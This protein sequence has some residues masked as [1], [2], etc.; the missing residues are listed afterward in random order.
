MQKYVC[1]ICGFV[2]DESKGLP[3]MGIAPGTPWDK[4]PDSWI[5]PLCGA[6]KSAFAAE[7]EKPIISEAPAYEPILS[8]EHEGSSDM[9]EMTFAELAALCSNLA[10]GCEKQYLSEESKL[11]TELSEYY[12]SKA[13]PTVQVNDNYLLSMV[14]D[15][16]LHQFPA[17]N[18]V[19]ASALDR[20]AKRA[21]TWSEKVTRMQSVLL[22]RYTA[23]GNTM[24]DGTKVWV[25]EICGFIFIGDA[26]PDICPICKVPN[27]K[28][29]EVT[30]A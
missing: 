30:S 8:K 6:P 13:K 19:A 23:E 10:K 3:D 21:L 20:G 12:G 14:A 4:L 16:L 1:S 24:L 15:D 7:S 25:C 28:I 22:S 17:A 11:F 9:R 29:A 27:M 2:Y 26:P 5:C 18:A